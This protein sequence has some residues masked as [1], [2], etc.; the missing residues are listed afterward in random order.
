MAAERVSAGRLLTRAQ[1]AIRQGDRAGAARLYRKVLDQ[2]PANRRARKGLAALAAPITALPVTQ[3]EIDAAMA[4][5]SAGEV[6]A[7]LKRAEALSARDPALRAPCDIRAACHRALGA[8]DKALPIYRDL[9]ERFPEDARVWR[10]CG[11]VLNDLLTLDE[12]VSCLEMAT[13]LDPEDLQGWLALGRARLTRGHPRPAF[14][15]AAQALARD[16]GHPGALNLL[17]QCLRDLGQ[18]L[19]ARQAHQRALERA[20]TGTDRATAHNGLGVLA[21]ALGEVDEA[22]MQYRAATRLMPRDMQ[23]HLNL[24]RQHRYTADS[25][26]L[27]TLRTLLNRQDEMTVLDRAHLHF[28]LFNALDQVDPG[29]DAG[30]A[31]LAEGN[32]LRQIQ[33][34]HSPGGSAASISAKG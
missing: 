7:A 11:L 20:E 25:A 9:L 31:H 13:R 17:G 6:R 27:A 18:A 15:A 1:S 2:F 3:A 8:P 21:G 30:F 29:S 5:Y 28:A 4:L 12:A 34:R 26:H 14:D 19:S 33:L 32:A 16:D 10:N 22:E 24:S 23:A